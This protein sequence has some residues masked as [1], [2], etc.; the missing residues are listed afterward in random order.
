[1][2]Y[3]NI[4]FKRLLLVERKTIKISDRYLHCTN[5]SKCHFV[6]DFPSLG[7]KHFI[8]LERRQAAWQENFC[9]AA[10]LLQYSALFFTCADNIYPVFSGYLCNVQIDL[11]PAVYKMLCGSLYIRIIQ[12]EAN[13]LTLTFHLF[14]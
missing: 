11:V 3:K 7:L 1:M 9:L 2:I 5:S 4:L 6:I 8:H 13:S 12:G 10:C 14:N